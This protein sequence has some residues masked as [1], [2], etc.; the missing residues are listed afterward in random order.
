M[1]SGRQKDYQT[2]K[3][4][5]QKQVN[6]VI[7]QVI[8]RARLGHV[9]GAFHGVVALDGL[10]VVCRRFLSERN[11]TIAHL[12]NREHN[13]ATAFAFNFNSFSHFY[14]LIQ[15]RFTK[16]NTLRLLPVLLQSPEKHHTKGN[17]Y[18]I[19]PILAA[20][21]I[22]RLIA[23]PTRWTDCERMFEKWASQLTEIFWEG[24]EHFV[25]ARLYL[26]TDPIDKQFIKRNG[27]MYAEAIYGKI[28]D[29]KE[30]LAL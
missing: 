23:S 12:D 11:K 16:K 5:K 6:D 19:S 15:F 22:L 26:I 18:G 28:K 29:W 3:V 9:T 1:M 20:R 14:C 24:I 8:T 13:F 27:K 30:L 25:D 7:L 17:R 4:T 10:A 21:I 2:E